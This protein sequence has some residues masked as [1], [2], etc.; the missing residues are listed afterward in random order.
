MRP[1]ESATEVGPQERLLPTPQPILSASGGSENT[2]SVL[3]VEGDSVP[4]NQ[5]SHG[6][7]D[8]RSSRTE[9]SR[10]PQPRK[11]IGK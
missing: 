10:R 1:E 6:T 5:T 8:H 2:A 7:L 11:I 9:G 3:R 4:M